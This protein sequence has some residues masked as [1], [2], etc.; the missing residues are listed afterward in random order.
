MDLE[1][2]NLDL[3]ERIRILDAM[4]AENSKLIAQTPAEAVRC[5][6][7]KITA[8]ENQVLEQQTAL[9]TT[10]RKAEITLR[11]ELDVCTQQITILNSKLE[12]KDAEIERYKNELSGIIME[13][14]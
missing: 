14:T 2:E 4:C 5:L 8:L 9:S 13:L 11:G 6:Q 10:A 12:A 1:A 7:S 3:R